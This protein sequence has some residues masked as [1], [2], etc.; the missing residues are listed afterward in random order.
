RISLRASPRH[1]HARRHR[2]RLRRAAKSARSLLP[3]PLRSS[4]HF[5]GQRRR[6]PPPLGDGLSPP[7]LFRPRWPRRSRSFARSPLRRHRQS[8]HPRRLQRAHTRL[9]RL[10][11]VHVLHRPRRKIPALRACRIRL[12]S[13][14]THVPLHAHRRSPSHVCRRNRRRPHHSAHLRHHERTQNRRS[15][16]RPRARRHRSP[17][18]P[19]LSQFPL[20]R[21]AGSLRL[22][23]LL[24]RR[25]LFHQR[26]QRTL[27][28][29]QTHRRSHP[30]RIRLHRLGSHR[31][32]NCRQASARAYRAQ[33]TPS[34]R[35]HRR[36]RRRRRPLAKSDR[37][38]RHPLQ[39]H[40][41]S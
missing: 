23:R 27:P 17:N 5:S 37:Q 9:A 35:L 26:P 31:R 10:L 36:N 4:Q 38:L 25:Q 20:Q 16:R 39:A 14:L 32:Q 6:R 33:R 41:P 13:P 34:R 8:A 29:N 2:A 21:H 28:R 30:R 15:L 24:Q 40:A 1:R 3:F 11:H 19:A 7:P 12:R 22:R 18:H